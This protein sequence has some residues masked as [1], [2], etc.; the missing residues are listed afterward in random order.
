MFYV[1]L[2][3]LGAPQARLN[4]AAVVSAAR[5][6]GAVNSIELTDIKPPMPPHTMPR[7]GVHGLRQAVHR[8]V[9][10]TP[11]Q[12]TESRSVTLRPSAQGFYLQTSHRSRVATCKSNLESA[13]THNRGCYAGRAGL[14]GRQQALPLRA[15]PQLQLHDRTCAASEDSPQDTG[16]NGPLRWHF[17]TSPANAKC[18]RLSHL[19]AAADE[20]LSCAA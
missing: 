9:V 7:A 13:G 4:L 8:A 19:V 20:A 15:W 18:R 6:L 10:I 3:K 11:Q 17:R 2:A 16:E 1:T 5:A 12:R 14:R